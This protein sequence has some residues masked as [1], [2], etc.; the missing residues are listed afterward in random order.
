MDIKNTLEAPEPKFHLG[1]TVTWNE[2][3]GRKKVTRTAVV[4]GMRY[5]SPM[6]RLASR[7]KITLEDLGWRYEVSWIEGKSVEDL[8][9]KWPG[10]NPLVVKTERSMSAV[11]LP[12][13]DAPLDKIREEINT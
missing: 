4:V 1:Q 9:R 11:K 2:S 6:H 8:A 12:S 7:E 3:S 13:S 5:L 10:G